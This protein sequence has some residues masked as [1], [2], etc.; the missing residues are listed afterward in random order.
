V[1]HLFFTPNMLPLLHTISGWL[2]IVAFTAK[3]ILHYWLDKHQ[4]PSLGLL[5][6][7]LVPKIYFGKYK[8]VVAAKY[9]W[10][11]IICNVFWRTM[12]VALLSNI[13][14]GTV[15]LYTMY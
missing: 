5:A 2:I 6:F 10:H 7:L 11:K 3:L 1:R 15:Q 4:Q 14:I 13:L 12:L 9:Y 8:E